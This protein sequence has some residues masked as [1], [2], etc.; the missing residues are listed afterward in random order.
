MLAYAR[1]E[2]LQERLATGNF[3][4]AAFNGGVPVG[5]M[6]IRSCCTHICLLFVKKE[7][8]RRGIA[9][10]LLELAVTECRARGARAG[11]LDVNSSPYAV[12]VYEKLGFVKTGDEMTVKGIRFTPMK[13]ELATWPW[14][15]LKAE[16]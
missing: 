4:F 15:T 14:D 3:A 6:E 8:Q 1:P 10:K 12:P 9:R 2:A 13:L 7:Y 16:S 11:F 5:Y